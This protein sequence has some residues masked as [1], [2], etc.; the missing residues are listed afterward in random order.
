[1]FLLI[2]I[3][4]LIVTLILIFY[5]ILG[6]VRGSETLVGNEKIVMNIQSCSLMIYDISLKST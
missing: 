5:Y 1:M 4:A 2:A 6:F 3:V